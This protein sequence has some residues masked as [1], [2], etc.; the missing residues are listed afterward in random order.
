LLKTLTD[1]GMKISK[2]FNP[3]QECSQVGRVWRREVMGGSQEDLIMA[4]LKLMCQER[5]HS[6][7][8][9]ERREKGSLHGKHQRP[10]KGISPMLRVPDTKKKS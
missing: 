10:D 1:K 3:T 7:W 2:T 8:Q 9:G 6:V 4:T 5:Q